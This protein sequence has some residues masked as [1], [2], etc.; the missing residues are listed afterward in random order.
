MNYRPSITPSTSSIQKSSFTGEDEQPS[1]LTLIE[2]RQN[3]NLIDLS[4]FDQKENKLIRV[5]VL[6]AFDPLLVKTENE[7][8][9]PKDGKVIFIV[10]IS[11]QI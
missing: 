1:I 9:Q 11:R 4:N 5:S 6:E 2:R 8:S 3:K 7:Y 10:R